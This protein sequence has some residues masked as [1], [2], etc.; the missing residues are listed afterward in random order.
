MNPSMQ[1]AAQPV[2]PIQDGHTIRPP[3][4][5]KLGISNSSRAVSNGSAASHP[6]AQWKRDQFIHS[7]GSTTELHTVW[8]NNWPGL[9]RGEYYEGKGSEDFVCILVQAFLLA[10][11]SG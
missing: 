7:A 9:S 8:I 2:G 11:S 1:A 5:Q 4:T 3:H 10:K 6:G